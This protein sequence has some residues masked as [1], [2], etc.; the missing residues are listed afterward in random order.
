MAII[1]MGIDFFERDIINCPLMKDLCWIGNIDV[2][3]TTLRKRSE[4][5]TR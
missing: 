1:V 2:Y 4:D 5:E 3:I